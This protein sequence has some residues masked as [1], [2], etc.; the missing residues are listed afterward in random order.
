M[1]EAALQLAGAA[2]ALRDAIGARQVPLRRDL[3]ERW[4]SLARGRV[5][6]DVY[7]R[8]WAAGGELT[9]QQTIA[10]ALDVHPTGAADSP[11]SGHHR[12]A[13]LA[14]LTARELEVLRLIARG[15]S[16]KEIGTQLV[17]SVRTVERHI[18]NLYGKIDARSKADA[19]AYAIHHGLV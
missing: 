18:T 17:L 3:L 12:N 1:T 14:G 2:A 4:L 8:H 10:L 16:N 9:M 19:T 7:A 15:R 5:A 13:E 11:T 6:E